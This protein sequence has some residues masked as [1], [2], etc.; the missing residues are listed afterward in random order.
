M[1]K[2][3]PR[4]KHTKKLLRI[5]NGQYTVF[6][7]LNG[8]LWV[9]IPVPLPVETEEP[10]TVAQLE[11]RVVEQLVQYLLVQTTVVETHHSHILL[12]VVLI[13]QRRPNHN[14][15]IT[16]H[17]LGQFGHS[18][19]KGRH[20]KKLPDPDGQVSDV[21]SLFVARDHPS[22][23]LVEQLK[24]IQSG[25]VLLRGHQFVQQDL[26]VTFI[27]DTQE[28]FQVRQHLDVVRLGVAHSTVVCLVDDAVCVGGQYML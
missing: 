11:L 10:A 14:H 16:G 21:D 4:I 17:P 24:G 15:H 22:R 1:L 25:V 23:V 6:D 9:V 18:R 7:L 12:R 28:S 13:V 20:L 3:I 2:T 5:Q 27:G 19:A 26:T 8:H